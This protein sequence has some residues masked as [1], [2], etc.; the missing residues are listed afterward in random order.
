MKHSKNIKN[1]TTWD[2]MIHDKLFI[3]A[4]TMPVIP[5]LHCDHNELGWEISQTIEPRV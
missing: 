4:M 3:K 2:T 5:A 1:E